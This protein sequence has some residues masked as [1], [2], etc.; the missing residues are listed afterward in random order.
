[1]A[2]WVFTYSQVVLMWPWTRSDSLEVRL[3][4]LM[5]LFESLLVTLSLK[6]SIMRL[7]SL[8]TGA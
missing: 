7:S 4:I 5:F 3:T 2:L 6:F 1:M 8:E